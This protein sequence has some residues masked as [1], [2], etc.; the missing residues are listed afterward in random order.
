MRFAPSNLH[1]MWVLQVAKTLKFQTSLVKQTD[2]Q[3]EMSVAT[4][5][6]RMQTI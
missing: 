4:A 1:R 5:L 3:L 6:V 2:P